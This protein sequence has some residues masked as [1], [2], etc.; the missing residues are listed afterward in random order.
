[1]IDFVKEFSKDGMLG[2]D[3]KKAIQLKEKI[4]L[5]QLKKDVMTYNLVMILC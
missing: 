1:M 4:S 3:Y 2:K 5:D